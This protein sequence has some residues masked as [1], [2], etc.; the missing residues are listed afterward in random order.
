M[1]SEYLHDNNFLSKNRIVWMETLTNL[2]YL[3]YEYTNKMIIAY[4]KRYLRRNGYYE[5]EMEL[6]KILNNC[7]NYKENI[8]IE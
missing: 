4:D 3:V 8:D 2:I 1:L 5:V 7:V 6:L